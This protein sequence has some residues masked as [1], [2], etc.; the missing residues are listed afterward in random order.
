[1]ALLLC[2]L[3]LVV[4]TL[5]GLSAWAETI[6]QERLA[7]NLQ[8]SERARQ[9]ALAAQQWAEGWLMQLDGPVPGICSHPCGGLK[10]HAPGSLPPH[11]EFEDLSWWM[12]QG[13][14]AG[15]DPLTGDRTGFISVGSID[16]SM[17]IIEAV[18]ETPPMNN[19]NTHVQTWYRIL[20]RGSGRTNTGGSVVES[21]VTRPWVSLG[22]MDIHDTGAPGFCPGTAPAAKCGRVTWRELR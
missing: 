9:S 10:I 3:F 2:L 18:R 19:G 13:H 11:P 8:E 21:I 15:I 6:M 12:E 5:Q 4:L 1:M 17:W 20:A 14:E 22:S 16:P 7:A